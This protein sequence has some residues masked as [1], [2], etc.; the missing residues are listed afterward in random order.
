M[1]EVIGGGAGAKACSGIRTKKN[2]ND[3]LLNSLLAFGMIFFDT[4]VRDILDVLWRGL[5]SIAGTKQKYIYCIDISWPFEM[6]WTA[7]KLTKSP[8]L[9]HKSLK[10][11][12][13]H[14]T[15]VSL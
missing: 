14:E 10:D 12:S 9:L 11:N 6:I 8:Y 4:Y 5:L 13:E 1:G 15:I 7:K 3:H 2:H